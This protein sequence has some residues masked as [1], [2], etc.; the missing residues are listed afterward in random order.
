MKRGR[1]NDLALSSVLLSLKE[2]SISR[3]NFILKN[4]LK[5]T[6]SFFSNHSTLSYCL[7]RISISLACLAIGLT[8]IFILVR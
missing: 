6:T 2:N 5:Q 4:S 8:L 7:K 1:K 3:T